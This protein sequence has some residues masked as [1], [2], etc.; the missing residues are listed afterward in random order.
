MDTNT[1]TVGCSLLSLASKIVG[2][3]RRSP[4]MSFLPGNLT[5]AYP[6]FGTLSELRDKLPEVVD[7]GD[8]SPA[9]ISH[10]DGHVVFKIHLSLY[11]TILAKTFT[12]SRI[13]K[14]L[15]KARKSE[16]FHAYGQAVI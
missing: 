6:D 1:K 9:G 10:S 15:E 11:M 13:S 2:D 3:L 14:R 12:L 8:T 4:R 16:Y 5:P 7:H